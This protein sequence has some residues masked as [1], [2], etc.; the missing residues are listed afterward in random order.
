MQLYQRLSGALRAMHNCQESKNIEW[1]AKHHDTIIALQEHIPHGSGLDNSTELDL[2]N[3]TPEKL[4]FAADFHHMNGDGYYIGWTDHTVVV[5]ASL[6]FG[7]DVKVTGRDRNQ[8]KEYIGE[9]F[10]TALTQEI[11]NRSI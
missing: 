11:P 5:K 9:I 3:S 4:V 7:I 1:E 2:E 8:I 10:Q 6:Q